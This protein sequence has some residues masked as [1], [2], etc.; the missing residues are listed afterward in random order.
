M[1]EHERIGLRTMQQPERHTSVRRMKERALPFD[2]VPMIG[3]VVRRQHLCSTRKEIGNHCIDRDPFTGNH[4]ARL[5]GCTKRGVRSARFERLGQ[6]ERRVFLAK[7]TVSANG[8]H[9]HAGTLASSACRENLVAVTHIVQLHAA[10]FRG[11]HQRRKRSQSSV[12]AAYHIEPARNRVFKIR[13]PCVRQLAAHR[14]NA[15]DDTSRPCC[16]SCRRRHAWH[17]DTDRRRRQTPF[18][19]HVLPTPVA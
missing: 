14:R 8:R 15:D 10:R 9:T 18:T 3:R 19:Q 11:M 17:A 2:H 4:D 6:R 12:H 13:Q 5:T 7:R 16:R 1:T